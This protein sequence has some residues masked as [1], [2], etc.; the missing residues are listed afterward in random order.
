MEHHMPP[1]RTDFQSR[2]S[3][4]SFSVFI[5]KYDWKKNPI[6]FNFYILQSW[7][8]GKYTDLLY[9]A[10]ILW[11]ANLYFSRFSPCTVYHVKHPLYLTTSIN[12]AETPLNA[13][14]HWLE[15]FTREVLPEFWY[16]NRSYP[17]ALLCV[18]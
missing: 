9:R 17:S 8:L 6:G 12:I 15:G 2:T 4:T 13:S 16:N 10:I 3:V 7:T 18:Y 11:Y 14:E 1:F 5:F